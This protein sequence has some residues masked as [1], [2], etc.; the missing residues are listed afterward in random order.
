MEPIM[1]LSKELIEYINDSGYVYING[2]DHI[3]L[4][5][6]SHGP[7]RDEIRKWCNLWLVTGLSVDITTSFSGIINARAE[8]EISKNENHPYFYEESFICCISIGYDSIDIPVFNKA[9]KK[10]MCVEKDSDDMMYPLCRGFY[11]KV[12]L[13]CNRQLI[14]KSEAVEKQESEVRKLSLIDDIRS[15]HSTGITI[16]SFHHWN[17]HVL[18][19]LMSMTEQDLNCHL[20]SL[21]GRVLLDAIKRKNGLISDIERFYS[22]T[23]EDNTYFIGNIY[24]VLK[25]MS[26]EDLCKVIYSMNDDDIKERLKRVVENVESKQGIDNLTMSVFL[27][28]LF[29]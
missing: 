19:E 1:E 6:D 26:E 15:R 17:T 7:Y 4:D 12:S 2:L 3:V 16:E 9:F 28:R 23:D 25:T 5:F 24:P 29:E 8:N 13:K 20:H 21:D 11:G 10:V 27:N 18:P 22:R 14:C